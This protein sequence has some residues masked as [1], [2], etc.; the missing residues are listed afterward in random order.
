[1]VV[2]GGW[3]LVFGGW[4][5]LVGGW[6]VAGWWWWWR[7]QGVHPNCGRAP[8]AAPTTQSTPAKRQRPS[9]ARATPGHTPHPLQSTK[10]CACHANHTGRAAETQQCQ[11]DARAYTPPPTKHN[12]AC[13]ANHTGRAAETQRRQGFSFVEMYNRESKKPLSRILLHPV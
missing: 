4:W 2:G 10:C 5:W 7:Y 3:C 6:W 1:M 12:C 9:D 13:P 11:G 8:S